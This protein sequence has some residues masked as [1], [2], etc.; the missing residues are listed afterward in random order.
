MSR[1]RVA[2]AVD[3]EESDHPTG[4][5]SDQRPRMSHYSRPSLVRRSLRSL[6]SLSSL[7][8]SRGSLPGSIARRVLK[9]S[10]TSSDAPAPGVAM[11]PGV[12]ERPERSERF[13]LHDHH[14]IHNNPVASKV[15]KVWQHTLEQSRKREQDIL[16][17]QASEFAW[18]ETVGKLQIR[19]SMVGGV[20]AGM[21]NGQLGE[22]RRRFVIVDSNMAEAGPSSAARSQ[23]GEDLTRRTRRSSEP[24]TSAVSANQHYSTPSTD[25]PYT[26]VRTPSELEMQN[27]TSQQS[28]PEQHSGKAGLVVRAW[29]W[30]AGVRVSATLWV[31]GEAD[32]R[33]HRL[34]FHYGSA[35]RR[36]WNAFI[37]ILIPSYS[38]RSNSL[39]CRSTPYHCTP[40][41][42]V[43]YAPYYA[44]PCHVTVCHAMSCHT[45]PR[46]G[47]GMRALSLSSSS[48]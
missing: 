48:T 40:C 34:V 21:S 25:R 44:M 6:G 10:C 5:V 11:L 26:K 30:L 36:C 4:Q 17:K 24:S 8:S 16:A 37:V 46:Q 42:A 18:E 19:M 28:A 38:I 43:P 29:V 2:P 41:H 7:S 35:F 27:R 3:A 15:I 14:G 12:T 47:T 20:A 33:Q 13:S 23:D 9:R 39:P 22:Q 45:M 32:I 31:L 1:S